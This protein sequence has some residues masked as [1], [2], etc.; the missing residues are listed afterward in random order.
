MSQ[1]V[2]LRLSVSGCL[3]Q[4]VCLRLSVSGCLSR[5]VCLRLSVSGCLSQAVS[6]CLS[7]AHLCVVDWLSV[8]EPQPVSS[9]YA[10]RY[11]FDVDVFR[12]SCD[13]GGA[14]YAVCETNPCWRSV[15]PAAPD[16]TCHVQ[17]CGRCRAL[18]VYAGRT[19]DCHHSSGPHSPL[20]LHL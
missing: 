11:C 2:C 16:A 5:A 14:T 7:Q 10:E 1:A 12:T 17:L 9:V 6:G 18:W 4:A 15:C 19:V 3:S 20:L 13:C 8:S